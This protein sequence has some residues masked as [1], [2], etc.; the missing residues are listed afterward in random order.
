MSGVSEFILYAFP[1]EGFCCPGV[2]ILKAQQD[3]GLFYFLLSFSLSLLPIDRDSIRRDLYIRTHWVGFGILDKYSLVEC[4]SAFPK[5]SSLDRQVIIAALEILRNQ[6]S[7][8]S[9]PLSVAMLSA[10]WPA[11]PL[12]SKSWSNFRTNA[13]FV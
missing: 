2:D 9:C 4:G 7:A 3:R 13:E 8:I 5:Q 12:P 11:S 6:K 10:L 1:G